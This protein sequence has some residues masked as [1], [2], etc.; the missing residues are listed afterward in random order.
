M[1]APIQ[2]TSNLL[3]ARQNMSDNNSSSVDNV[4]LLSRDR[5][6]NSL[7]FSDIDIEVGPGMET[8]LVRSGRSR[9]SRMK[10]YRNNRGGAGWL[11]GSSPFL[12]SLLA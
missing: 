6:T 1:L 4:A 2:S 9:Q 3:H 8:E 7:Q 10:E 11:A 5:G 12:S